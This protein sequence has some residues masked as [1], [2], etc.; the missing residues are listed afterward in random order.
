MGTICYPHLGTVKDVSVATLFSPEPH[1]D[2]VGAGTCLAHGQRADML[3]ADEFRQIAPLLVGIAVL[4]NLVDTEVR[5][6]SVRK[7]YRGRGAAQLLHG[8]HMLDIA[9]PGA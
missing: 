1:A 5:V 8:D 7:A 9:H 6:R 2:D 4:E 3:A